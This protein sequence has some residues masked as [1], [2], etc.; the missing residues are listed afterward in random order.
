MQKKQTL[1]D[2]VAAVVVEYTDTE[3]EAFKERLE[4]DL[5]RTSFD[6]Q[7]DSGTIKMI[8][9]NLGRCFDNV[10]ME[11]AK[12]NGYL[13]QLANKTYGLIPRQI[14]MNAIGSNEVS[15]KKNSIHAPEVY[16]NEDGK[17]FNLYAI[18]AGL[19]REVAYLQIVMKQLEY[20]RSTLIAYLTANKI[21]AGLIGD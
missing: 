11:Y 3:F 17:T 15:R 18:Q 9:T 2:A 12:R 13:E 14:A 21:E 7:A 20:K 8:L 4:K 6:E 16:K 10:T 19:E 5:L 1:Q